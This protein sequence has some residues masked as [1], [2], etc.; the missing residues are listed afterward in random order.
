ML[1]NWTLYTLRVTQIA[2]LLYNI[3]VEYKNLITPYKVLV[4]IGSSILAVGTMM[5]IYMT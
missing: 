2:K 5:M 3:I 1:D 4:Y